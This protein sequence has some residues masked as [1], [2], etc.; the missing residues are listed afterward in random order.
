MS[1]WSLLEMHANALATY[2]ARWTDTLAAHE[3]EDDSMGSRAAAA[4]NVLLHSGNCVRYSNDR[5]YIELVRASPCEDLVEHACRFL[6]AMDFSMDCAQLLDTEDFEFDDVEQLE[7]LLMQRD[8]FETVVDVAQ[9]LLEDPFA[10]GAPAPHEL[11]MAHGVTANIDAVLS[12]NMELLAIAARER[13]TSMRGLFATPPDKGRY[14]WFYEPQALDEACQSAF[15]SVLQQ[16]DHEDRPLEATSSSP[17]EDVLDDFVS[18]LA[19]VEIDPTT[20]SLISNRYGST[21]ILAEQRQKR[22]DFRL[23]ISWHVGP[24]LGIDW[25]S[26]ALILRSDEGKVLAPVFFDRGGVATFSS[27]EA[28]KYRA[29]F[30]R[31]A[32]VFPLTI[33]GAVSNDGML[34]GEYHDERFFFKLNADVERARANSVILSAIIDEATQEVA[35]LDWPELS[36]R[37]SMPPRKADSPALTLAAS[38]SRYVFMGCVCPCP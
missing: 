37:P 24:L 6:Q 31:H 14:W 22:T 35:Y 32:L 19:A 21:S 9:Q 18:T 33:P 26:C 20:R 10:D 28:G 23:S 27:V 11:M 25:A 1:N 36:E 29:F 38:G 4:Y 13:V 15:L 3:L 30:V 17:A 8:D 34:E 5:G 16:L 12:R 2:L 7:S